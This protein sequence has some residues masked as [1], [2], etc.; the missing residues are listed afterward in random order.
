MPT[1]STVTPTAAQPTPRCKRFAM[2]KFLGSTIVFDLYAN[3]KEGESES[4]VGATPLGG[5]EGEDEEGE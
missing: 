3:L 5:G 2:R 1:C 4:G